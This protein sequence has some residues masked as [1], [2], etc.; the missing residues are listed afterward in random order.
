MKIAYLSFILFLL[1]SCIGCVT[2]EVSHPTVFSASAASIPPGSSLCFISDIEETPDLPQEKRKEI[3][4]RIKNALVNELQTKGFR[5]TNAS[6]TDFFISFKVVFDEQA[7]KELTEGPNL[8][9]EM[10]K[11]KKIHNGS[12][13]INVMTRDMRPIWSGAYNADI[14]LS[15]SEKEKDARVANAV[16]LILKNFP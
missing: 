2:Q 9:S 13:V 5:F 8:L 12:L 1:F 10:F 16:S 4:N 15:V 6:D 7:R 11:G 14:V 3:K